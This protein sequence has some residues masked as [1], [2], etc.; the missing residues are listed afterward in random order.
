MRVFS[1]ATRLWLMVVICA[2][3][4]ACADATKQSE[5]TTTP[6][7]GGNSPPTIA[8]QP[9]AEVVAGETYEFSPS[10]SD[11]D[12]DSLTFSVRNK[13]AWANFNGTNGRLSGTP[14]AGDVGSYS[15]IMIS[16]SDGTASASLPGFAV[17]VVQ[18][19]NGS[20]TLSWVPPTTRSDGSALVNLAGFNVY[21]G[22][23]SGSYSN[24]ITLD[25]PGLTAYVIG[26]LTSGRWF[27]AMTAFDGG[28]AESNHSA[29]ASKTIP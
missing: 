28:G 26:N 25:N 4:G 19:G 2:L 17:D 1:S 29:E 16:V 10:A 13:P 12:G 20:A 21:Y 27:F 15:N 6:P 3:L 7:P 9:F 11:P 22:R 23:T 24:R 14:T 5:G 8:G 18:A